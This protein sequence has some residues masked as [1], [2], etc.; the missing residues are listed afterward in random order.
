MNALDKIRQR[1][2]HERDEE[3]RK[4]QDWES[5]ATDSLNSISDELERNG[6]VVV[7]DYDTSR[8]TL[9]VAVGRYT[10]MVAYFWQRRGLSYLPPVS[11]A[12]RNS[13]WR[14][15]GANIEDIEQALLNDALAI[16]RM[17]GL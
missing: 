17:Y 7:K 6:W 4:I 12:I 14:A 16:E 1:A 10:A 2:R 11:G 13:G 3:R 8:P 9:E 15:I 5:W